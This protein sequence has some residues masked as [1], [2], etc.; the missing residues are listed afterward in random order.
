MNIIWVFVRF[1]IESDLYQLSL[2]GSERLG[3]DET[4]LWFS[5]AIRLPSDG[6]LTY[7]FLYNDNQTTYQSQFY[8]LNASDNNISLTT[9]RD[10]DSP[11]IT[12][13]VDDS[14]SAGR[15]DQDPTSSPPSPVPTLNAEEVKQL[16][17]GFY[18][19]SDT[20]QP[21]SRCCCSVGPIQV[22]LPE[23][24]QMNNISEA[25]KD[26]AIYVRSAVDGGVACFR[27][28]ELGG[29]CVIESP[30]YAKCQGQESEDGPILYFNLTLQDDRLAIEN[31]MYEDCESVG[32]RSDVEATTSPSSPPP[33]PSS[34]VLLLLLFS[35]ALFLS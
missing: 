32:I 12:S 16:W 11:T 1:L 30:K 3:Q 27:R 26:K 6:V 22:S 31:S 25:E 14:S 20:C 17:V 35:S 8:T 21:T 5:R 29:I 34:M 13:S 18:D 7:S 2:G 23:P 24:S 15:E 10:L 4:G 9:E 19:S 33:H 28:E